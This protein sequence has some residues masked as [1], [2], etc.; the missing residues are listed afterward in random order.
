MADTEVEQTLR[1]IRE[2]VRAEVR[3]RAD[4]SPPREG[5]AVAV[6]SAPVGQR[7]NGAHA[8]AP[9]D[10]HA[11]SLSGALARLEANLS[12]A[13]RA[14]NKLPP[15]MSYRTGWAARLEL[16]VKRQIKRA[17]HWFT[18]E[19]VNFNASAY[20]AL[21]DTRAA[22]DE[23][24]RQL[25][26]HR[27]QL[28]R[29]EEALNAE[30]ASRRQALAEL[31]VKLD[32]IES[33]GGELSSHVGALA[34]RL[35]SGER[36]LSEADAVARA[37]EARVEAYRAEQGALAE[38]LRGEQES[39]AKGLRGEQQSHVR[40]LRVEL[41]ERVGHVLEEQRVLFKQLSLEAGER[42]VLHDRARR[43]MEARLGE[44]SKVV[45]RES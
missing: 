19:Q 13:E 21:R 41:L 44:I 16:W 10:A 35:D 4:V 45:N 40:D 1:E 3:S 14:W 11:A 5:L 39:V 6:E 36:R 23:Y 17:T 20:H 9:S 37:T 29:V 32:A 8:A 18:W 25:A 7:A 28:S 34:L 27:Q 33:I 2:R 12:T 26:D 15:L 38:S 30:A 42:A 31:T 43:D 22:L 24:R